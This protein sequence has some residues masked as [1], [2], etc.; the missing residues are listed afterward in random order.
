MVTLFVFAA[1]FVFVVCFTFISILPIILNAVASF[2]VYKEVRV[3]FSLRSSLFLSLVFSFLLAANMR[4][5]DY[6]CDI[7]SFRENVLV[8]KESVINLNYGERVYFST[9]SEDISYKNNLMEF[10]NKKFSGASMSSYYSVPVVKKEIF[11]DL[12]L[13]KGLVVSTNPNEKTSVFVDV[14]TDGYVLSATYAAKSNGKIVYKK[15]YRIRKM[16]HGEIEY[17]DKRESGFLEMLISYSLWSE[18]L[19]QLPVFLNHKETF[20]EFLD[21]SF[22]VERKI[23]TP[24]TASAVLLDASKYSENGNYLNLQNVT[25]CDGFDVVMRGVDIQKGINAELFSID[26]HN[27]VIPIGTFDAD[28]VNFVGC[29]KDH[30]FIVDFYDYGHDRVEIYEYDSKGEIIKLRSYGLTELK[31]Y[32]NV[33]FVYF[34]IIEDKFVVGFSGYDV[35]D[36]KKYSYFE[37]LEKLNN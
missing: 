6:V 36:K 22:R 16:Y 15:S 35:E 13:N 11:R 21:E 29:N 34:E 24:V 20:S 12:M 5:V 31:S 26:N 9:N 7:F 37:L 4:I 25:H 1:I 23:K 2:L 18:L 8:E 32:R 17:F 10:P 27:L 3:Y 19:S 28:R 30:F 33:G 14:K